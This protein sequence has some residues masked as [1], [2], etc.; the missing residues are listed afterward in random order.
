MGVSGNFIEISDAF[1]EFY[2]GISGFQRICKG[3]QG[4]SGGFHRGL[5]RASGVLQK[6]FREF[7]G[8][9]WRALA[10]VPG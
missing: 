3:L 8:F 9:Q 4:V 6:V 1:N 2:E 10:E 5:I 7:Q